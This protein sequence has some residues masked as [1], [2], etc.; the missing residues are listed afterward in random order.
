MI[1]E[2]GQLV[3]VLLPQAGFYEKVAAWVE[4]NR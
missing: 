4:G 1:D 3:D 2:D